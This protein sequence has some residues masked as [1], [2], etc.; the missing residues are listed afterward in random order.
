METRL[1]KEDL[2]RL[3]LLTGFKNDFSMEY[4]GEGRG[5]AGG[6]RLLWN[7]E[8]DIPIRSHSPNHIGGT[9]YMLAEEES[10]DFVGIYRFLEEQHK[11]NTWQLV[12][13]VTRESN[14]NV[15]LFGDFNDIIRESEK[16]GGNIRTITQFSWSRDALEQCG[17][18]DMSFIGYPFTWSNGMKGRENIQC[19]LD[20]GLCSSTFKDAF[21][22]SLVYHLPRH[23]LDHAVLCIV[24]EK[25]QEKE[26]RTHL[27]RF[28]EVGTK[29]P[30]CE[31]L[32]KQ[33]WREAPDSLTQK[34]K[35]VQDL[36]MI[37]KEYRTANVEKELKRIESLFKEETCW[38]LRKLCGYNGAEQ[39]G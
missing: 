16:S 33:I 27:F 10:W 26:R 35:L 2:D 24:V 4:R 28:E 5:R 32:V 13:E 6:L 31:N 36:N 22:I 25:Y 39:H 3:C 30:R 19:G 34:V 23:G 15:L 20:R 1:N 14:E 7:K 18:Q 21:P 17:L 8:V 29:D 9:F 38:P 11:C 12:K 37:F